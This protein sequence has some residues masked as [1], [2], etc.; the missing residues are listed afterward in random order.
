MSSTYYLDRGSNRLLRWLI[1]VSI[2]IHIPMYLYMNGLLTS[3]MFQY[4]DLSLREIKKPFGR[5]I[6]RPPVLPK[7]QT[8]KDSKIKIQQA[9]PI[10]LPDISNMNITQ[11]EDNMVS[12]VMEGVSGFVE[13][14]DYKEMV[15]RKIEHEKKYPLS[16]DGTYKEA[17]VSLSFII[18]PDG[19]IRNLK[20]VKPC[21]YAELN[22]AALQAVRDS[23]PFPRPPS[24]IF[25]GGVE[26]PLNLNF[27]LL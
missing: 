7:K 10:E 27:E 25:K 3:K 16:T 17:M 5:G 24:N 22:R 2:V 18:N 14:E 6:P 13:G 12:G 21:P 1:I 19:T 11:G 20:I 23:V 15:L 4:I 9:A 8:K 26:V